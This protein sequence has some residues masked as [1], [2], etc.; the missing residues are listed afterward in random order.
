MF[1]SVF[2]PATNVELINR[3]NK[4]T[5]E[6]KPDWGKMSADQMFAHV[7]VGYDITYGKIDVSYS[8]FMKKNGQTAPIFLIEGGRDFEAEKTKLIEY[9]KRV[10]SDGV[11]FFKGKESSSF[12]KMTVQEWSNQFWKH[13]DHHLTQFGV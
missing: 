1:P 8:W 2:D 3:I 11:A 7:N 5:P 13:L 12:G 9:I 10:E 4:I 6:K